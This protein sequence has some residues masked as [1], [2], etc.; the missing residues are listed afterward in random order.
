MTVAYSA[1]TATSDKPS[2]M[3]VTADDA[4]TVAFRDESCIPDTSH[5]TSDSEAAVDRSC[6]KAPGYRAIVVSNQST[7]PRTDDVDIYNA[8]IPDF[9]SSKQSSKHSQTSSAINRRMR[10][11]VVI[12]I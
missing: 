2:D 11:L 4:V 12:A 7:A 9:G 5:Q 6:A 1:A 10:N 8:Q 3:K